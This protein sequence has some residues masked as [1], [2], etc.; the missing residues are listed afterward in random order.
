[1][2]SQNR[3]PGLSAIQTADRGLQRLQF[4]LAL[5]MSATDGRPPAETLTHAAETAGAELVFVLPMPSRD[6]FTAVVRLADEGR[7][8]FLQVGTAD[9]GF[10]VADEAEMD[11]ILLGLAR[12]S[13]DV[14]RRMSEDREVAGSLAAA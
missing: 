2:N 1:M 12:A 10:A 6:G 11:K 7:D 3:T 9:G 8:Y 14:L 5:D 4:E 13:V